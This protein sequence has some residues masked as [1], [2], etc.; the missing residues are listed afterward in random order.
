LSLAA[1]VFGR[2]AVD[3][4]CLLNQVSVCLLMEEEKEVVVVVAIFQRKRRKKEDI[5][6]LVI[7][8]LIVIF[9]NCFFDIRYNNSNQ[10]SNKSSINTKKAKEKQTI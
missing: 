1:G 3:W 4:R 10:L 7:V 5:L 6:L 9:V 8:F 2:M